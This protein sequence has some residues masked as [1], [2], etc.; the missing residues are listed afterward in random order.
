[1]AVKP[2]RGIQLVQWVNKHAGTIQNRYRVRINRKDL[3]VDRLF[4]DL[5]EAEEFLALSSVKKGKE[6]IFSI[7]EEERKKKVEEEARA[8]QELLTNPPLAIY[9]KNISI[10]MC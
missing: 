2:A 1:M 3:Q 5:K 7:T 8:Y 9:L 10:A 6:I 4:D